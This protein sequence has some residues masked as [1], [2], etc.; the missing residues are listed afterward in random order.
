MVLPAA[1][2]HAFPTKFSGIAAGMQVKSNDRATQS[3]RAAAGRGGDGERR[4]LAGGARIGY[5]RPTMLAVV[6]VLTPVSVKS[7]VRSDRS[8]EARPFRLSPSH[9][10]TDSQVERQA[11]QNP[12][13]RSNMGA[14]NPTTS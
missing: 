6:H 8:V 10:L 1:D 11:Y 14:L 2:W 3:V 13:M 7:V 12:T 5:D 4:P 9:L